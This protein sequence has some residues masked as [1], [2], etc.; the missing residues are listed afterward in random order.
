MAVGSSG[1]E[2]ISS[3]LAG[4][5][6]HWRLSRVRLYLLFCCDQWDHI[7]ASYVYYCCLNS[8]V[9]QNIVRRPCY[10]DPALMRSVSKNNYLP[11]LQ[12]N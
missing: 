10:L 7:P 12:L 3:T 5:I 1:C 2:T 4:T 11:A 6:G 8:L 9:L